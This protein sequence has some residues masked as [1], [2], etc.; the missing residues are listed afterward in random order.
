MFINSLR[1]SY[2]GDR[3]MAFS[4]SILVFLMSSMIVPVLA[5]LGVLVWFLVRISTMNKYLREIR[6]MMARKEREKE[7]PKPQ[8]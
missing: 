1:R 6:D 5:S 4:D 2:S 3:K 7:L 8:P